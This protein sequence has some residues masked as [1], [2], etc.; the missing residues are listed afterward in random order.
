M[1]KQNIKY[2][3]SNSAKI[4]PHPAELGTPLN[5]RGETIVIGGGCFWCTEAIFQKLKGVINVTSGYAGGK[6]EN[7]DWGKVATGKT[8]HAEVIKVEFDPMII[9]LENILDVFFALHDPTTMNRHGA[10]TGPQYRSIIL[11]TNSQ[12]ESVAQKAKAEIPGAVTEIKSLV[13]F[14][15]AEEYHQNYYNENTNKQYCQVV[16]SPK[17]KKLRE[18]FGELTT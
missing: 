9:S 13:K 14:F 7:P 3:P 15:P 2:H 18:K 5:L 17:L 11:Y 12:Q 16:I 10:D 1:S 6:T 4:S 8:G